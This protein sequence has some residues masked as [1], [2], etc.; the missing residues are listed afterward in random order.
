MRH[1][2]EAFEKFRENKANVEKELGVYIKQLRSNQDGEYLSGEFKSYLDQEGIISQLSSP[3][4]PHQNGVSKRRN[5]TL[6]EIVR[7]MLCYS[8]LLKLF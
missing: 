7:S 5:I 1:K 3:V 2:S 6:L 8:S 4:T